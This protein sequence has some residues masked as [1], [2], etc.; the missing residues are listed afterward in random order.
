MLTRASTAMSNYTQRCN[1]PV[2]A[3]IDTSCYSKQ[4]AKRKHRDDS[5][6]HSFAIGVQLICALNR[7][8]QGNPNSLFSVSWRLALS[9]PC[10]GPSLTA[11]LCTVTLIVDI[12]HLRAYFSFLPVSGSVRLQGGRSKLDG[13]VEVYLGGAWG[14]ICS[15]GWGDEDAAVV[16]RQLGN[17]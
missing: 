5:P 3:P 14:S 11:T 17:G 10:H 6:A 8:R 9:P 15:D 16:C 4:S 12:S 13:R 2:S 1:I 7:E